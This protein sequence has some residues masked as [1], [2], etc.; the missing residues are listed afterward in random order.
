[1]NSDGI[2][3][4]TERERTAIGLAAVH[5]MAAILK[6]NNKYYINGDSGPVHPIE[7]VQLNRTGHYYFETIAAASIAWC[8]FYK[9]WATE[10]NK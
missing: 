7:A 8:D 10:E 1:M 5:G 2:D 9:L 4:L 3:W 6:D